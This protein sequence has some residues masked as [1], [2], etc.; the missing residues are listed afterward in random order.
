MILEKAFGIIPLRKIDSGFEVFLI[1]MKAGHVGF[2]K[3]H[4]NPGENQ[5]TTAERELFE[6]T[7]LQVLKYLSKQIFFES[8]SFQRDGRKILKSVGY[9]LAEV[10]GNIVLEKNEILDGFWINF[11]KAINEI[12]FSEGKNLAIKISSL[13]QK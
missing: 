4:A 7:H 3:G 8:Y 12:T 13:L 5:K 6:E 1:K 11:K 10:E 9:Y 2:P